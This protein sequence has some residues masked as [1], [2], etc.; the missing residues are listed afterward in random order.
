M[1]PMRTQQQLRFNALDPGRML[2]QLDHVLEQMALDIR[3]RLGIG[4]GRHG[5]N[6]AHQGFFILVNTE[7]VT[8]DTAVLYGDVAGQKT[9]VQVLQQEVG[10]GLK[11][12]TQAL[13]PDTALRL[14]HRF[15]IPGGEVAQIE[16]LKV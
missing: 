1:S 14:Q 8:A 11:I 5:K 4:R 2:Q 10:G 6:V 13:V 9:G 15:E 3:S 16:N 12:P 7:Y